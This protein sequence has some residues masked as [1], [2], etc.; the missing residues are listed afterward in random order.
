MRKYNLETSLVNENLDELLIPTQPVLHETVRI[1]DE[2]NLAKSLT[3]FDYNKFEEYSN[4][5][6]TLP[7]C[8]IQKKEDVYLLIKKHCGSFD[9]QIYATPPQ[10]DIDLIIT[11]VFK[12]ERHKTLKKKIAIKIRTTGSEGLMP[13]LEALCFHRKLMNSDSFHNNILPLFSTF[14]F[15][16]EKVFYVISEFLFVEKT[17]SDYINSKNY[18][19]DLRR[20]H[21]KKIIDFVDKI[22]SQLSTR[23]YFSD[24][25]ISNI[26]IGDNNKKIYFNDLEVSGGSIPYIVPFLLYVNDDKIDT[27]QFTGKY[28]NPDIIKGNDFFAMKMILLS[29]YSGVQYEKLIRESDVNKQLLHFQQ[30][31]NFSD[32]IPKDKI[33]LDKRYLEMLD[34]SNQGKLP[35]VQDIID[36]D[37][38]VQLRDVLNKNYFLKNDKISY[39]KIEMAIS[40]PVINK[41]EK[42]ATFSFYALTDFVS[43]D[44]N[45]DKYLSFFLNDQKIEE[46]N[47]NELSGKISFSVSF[48]TKGDYLKIKM[49][50]RFGDLLV[51][52]KI[53]I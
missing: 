28:N 1:V 35:I 3:S 47:Y 8:K 14:I 15:S 17:L 43:S 19:R 12:I 16:I 23:N 49:R 25:K 5:K 32:S 38:I 42:V 26:F 29:M 20:E 36:A 34:V 52:K 41:E 45:V 7:I 44:N 18:D 9:N 30:R 51:S 11:E 24:I 21:A 27:Q 48:F 6:E 50:N 2:V 37:N 40:S 33:I 4:N 46:G 53:K 10:K 22:H 13:F 31:D 39:N